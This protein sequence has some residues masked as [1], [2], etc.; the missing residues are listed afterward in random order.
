MAI[1]QANKAKSFVQRILN[2]QGP[3]NS[4]V[5]DLGGGQ[6]ATHKMAWTEADGKYRVYPTVLWDGKKL[7]D[8]GPDKAYDQVLRSGNFIDFD[9]P[10]AADWFSKNY[11]L[12]W[13]ADK[14]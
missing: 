3:Q 8:Y 14:R 4:P 7:V 1:L 13:P 9:S 5:L 2:Y 10:D 11:K 12:V 6:Y